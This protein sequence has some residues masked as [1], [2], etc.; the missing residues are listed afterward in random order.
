MVFPT[1]PKVV[2]RLPLKK[3]YSS[4]VLMINEKYI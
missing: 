2:L 4:L 3:R 1:A